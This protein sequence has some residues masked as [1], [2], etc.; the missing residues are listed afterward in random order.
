LTKLSKALASTPVVTADTALAALVLVAV[1]AVVLGVGTPLVVA[2]RSILAL[3]RLGASLSV[4]LRVV[5]NALLVDAVARSAS[6]VFVAV[7]T[8]LLDVLARATV[9]VRRGGA[10]G[11]TGAERVGRALA[12][13]GHTFA[14]VT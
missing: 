11:I 10:L 8:V 9:A 13:L 6:R 12:D 1:S 7:V 2:E 4:L 14:L 5:G 3:S